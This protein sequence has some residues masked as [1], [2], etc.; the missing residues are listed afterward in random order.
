MIYPAAD[1]LDAMSSKYALVIVAAKRARQV[2]EGARRF[3]PSKSG[4]PLTIALEEIAAG[5]IVPLLV[6]DPEKLPTSVAPTPVLG[7]LVST[8]MEEDEGI[9]EPTAAEI[10]ALLS[11]GSDILAYEEDAELDDEVI[12][13]EDDV[14]EAE[15]DDAAEEG[16]YGIVST[17]DDA[18]DAGANDTAQD[19]EDYM[20]DDADN[21]DEE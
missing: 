5:E 18:L 15:V 20:M 4:N 17:G 21:D 13:T 11:S 8:A 7:G 12:Q 9:H 10:G 3:V 2:K 19:A 16:P 14:M 6:G 1:K